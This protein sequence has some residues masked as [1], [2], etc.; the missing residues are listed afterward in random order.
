MTMM[1]VLFVRSDFCNLCRFI[2]H[3]TTFK[4]RNDVTGTFEHALVKTSSAWGKVEAKERGH[5]GRLGT[6]GEEG[7]GSS[8]SCES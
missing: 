5:R 3:V 4:L 6:V 2:H 8:E 1:S 7:E